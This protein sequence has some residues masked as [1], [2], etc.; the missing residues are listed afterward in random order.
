MHSPPDKTGELGIAD[1]GVG[2]VRPGRD[3]FDAAL[4]YVVV[5]CIYGGAGIH[6][7]T[8]AVVC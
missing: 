3:A 6:A 8:R 7:R 2:D 1:I 4:V 5:C